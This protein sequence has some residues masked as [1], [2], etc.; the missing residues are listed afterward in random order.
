[1]ETLTKKKKEK[2]QII[3]QAKKAQ[4]YLDVAGV[5]FVVLDRDGKV[6]LINKKGC[7]ILGYKEEEIIG[8]NWFNYFLPKKSSGN[9]KR[10]F[11]KLIKGQI[12]PA[13]YYENPVL[14][15]QGEERII[16]WHNTV[17]RDDQGRVTSTLSSGE[18]ITQR[19][20]SEELLKESEE[21][22]RLLVESISDGVY[23]FDRQWRYVL[24]NEAAVRML[25]ISRKKL[26]GIKLTD[27]FPE[28]ENSVFFEAYRYVMKNRRERVIEDELVFPDGRKGYYEVRIYPVTVGIT[29]IATDITQRKILQDQLV[30]AEKFAA[31]GQLAAGVAHEFNNIL[32]IIQGTVQLSK[33]SI[34]ENSELFKDLSTIERQTKRGSEIVENMMTFSRPREPKREVCD[35]SQV[36]DEVLRLQKDFFKYENIEVIRKYTQKQQVH[37]DCGQI[38]Q[39]LLNILLNARQAIKPQGK[40]MITVS[41]SD[42]EDLVRIEI[43]DN[44]IGMDEETRKNIFNPFFTTKGAHA[45]DRHGIKGTGLGLSVSYIIIMNH[46]GTI[47]VESEKGKGT[48]VIVTLPVSRIRTTV[49][50]TRKKF[51]IGNDDLKGL[52]VLII[53]DEKA[54][55][56]FLKRYLMKEK[57]QSVF[58]ATSGQQALSFAR[59]SK[60]DL[61]FIDLLMPDIKGED[62]LRELKRIKPD[63]KIV[64]MSGQ[65]ETDIDKIKKMGAWG[66][67]SKPF[68]IDEI[69]NMLNRIQKKLY[70]AYR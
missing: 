19:K 30:H 32:A 68:D 3:S 63:L 35:I 40:G 46:H 25:Q 14:T 4:Q 6:S 65:P 39:V 18:D 41:I 59:G 37:V 56:D 38:G 49:K 60:I 23:V 69:H 67:L 20:Q 7:Q 57:L 12:E 58:V 27:L 42:S 48:E 1:M 16:L 44:G 5:I 17:L 10:V 66:F 8:K 2:E 61:I 52:N 28:I 22:Y 31:V 55:T 24:V 50:G 9:T 45:R 36:M 64:V 29:C 54:I 62:L 26:I 13:E 33:L 21:K 51:F 53:D 15:K 70:K 43:R 34:E 11:N 47:H